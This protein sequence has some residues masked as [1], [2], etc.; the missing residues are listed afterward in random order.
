[1]KSNVKAALGM[2]V[3]CKSSSDADGLVAVPM[4][5][6]APS[7][8]AATLDASI[9]APASARATSSGPAAYV[10]PVSFVAIAKH[11]F[12]WAISSSAAR[13]VSARRSGGA[14]CAMS[15]SESRANSATDACSAAAPSSQNRA[16]SCAVG[17]A[18]TIASPASSR[19]GRPIMTR[20][21]PPRPTL[22]LDEH[23][24]NVT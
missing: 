4:L 3:A 1:M 17:T 18:L 21:R 24:V 11:A 16:R 20:P 10:A 14:P 13:C 12:V 9:D 22:V 2:L 19:S 15:T 7:T 5:E 23:P 8:S 6:T